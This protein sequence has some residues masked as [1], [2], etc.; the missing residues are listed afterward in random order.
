M[1]EDREKAFDKVREHFIANYG[2]DAT[3]LVA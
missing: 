3:R 2:E 1:K